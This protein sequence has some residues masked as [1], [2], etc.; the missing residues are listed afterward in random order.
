M[1]QLFCKQCNKKVE[2]IPLD[3]PKA[4]FIA[5][6]PHCGC[7]LS[8]HRL[9]APGTVI[10]SKYRIERELGRGGMGIVYLAKQVNLD[11]DIALKV[12]SDEMAS[13]KAFIDAF[14]REAKGAGALNHP[15]IVQAIDAGIENDIHYFVMEL[16]EGENLEVYTARKGA[17]PT[18]LALKCATSIADALTY[19]WDF[20][21]MAHRDIKPENIIMKN[22][23]EFKL[24]D[25]G[26]IKDCREGAA[27]QDENLMATPAYAPPEVIRSEKNVPGFKSDMYSFGATLYQLFAGH[28]PFVHDDPMVVCEMQQENQPPPL[29]A[30]NP[31]LPEEIS[32]L[33]DK[34]MEKDPE[35]RPGS[36]SAVLDRLNEITYAWHTAQQNQNITAPE[37]EDTGRKRNLKILTGTV[38]LLTLLFLAELILFFQ[39][40]KPQ[41]QTAPSVKREKPA[42]SQTVNQAIPLK[43]PG[44][45][46]AVSAQTA[47]VKVETPAPAPKPIVYQVPPQPEKVDFEELEDDPDELKLWKKTIRPTLPKDPY[48]RWEV[49]KDYLDDNLYAPKEARKMF[50]NLEKNEKANHISELKKLNK[51]CMA[52]NASP[53]DIQAL[54]KALEDAPLWA[55]EIFTL[56]DI[57]KIRKR[58]DEIKNEEEKKNLLRRQKREQLRQ[59]QEAILLKK[60]NRDA[61]LELQKIR[62]MTLSAKTGDFQDMISKCREKYSDCS[63]FERISEKIILLEKINKLANTPLF[64]IIRLNQKHL[65]G[66]II[67]PTHYPAYTFKSAENHLLHFIEKK[68]AISLGQKLHASW[69]EENQRIALQDLLYQCARQ[70]Q[71]FNH[72]SLVAIFVI[73]Q[74]NGFP[75]KK[76]FKKYSW[77][78]EQTRSE[79]LPLIEEIQQIQE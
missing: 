18:P 63:D 8:A 36:W 37:A 39:L 53:K 25:L 23:S 11:R 1:L 67:F 47:P 32:M 31:A 41:K 54:N 42:A 61:S 3:C 50:R 64:E 77:I 60:R 22:E 45:A 71:K 59:Q 49:L 24:A 57:E 10:N 21:K 19:A 46:Q 66:Q 26:L 51:S 79:V 38:I 5:S 78:P 30:V 70:L 15:N 65:K 20:K 27:A 12:L 35:K 14:F 73:A 29:I 68:G 13:D 9:L 58:S 44:T 7:M 17:L 56:E 4:D 6:C 74:S 52:K 33:V 16:I 62:R 76:F 40:P 28:A 75:V 55:A 34:L 2:A 72:Q 43:Q 48:G 69:L